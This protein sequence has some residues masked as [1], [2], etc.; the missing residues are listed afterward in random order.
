MP[1]LI[2]GGGRVASH[3][4]ELL[5]GAGCAVS[6]IA[7][8]AEDAIRAGSRHGRLDW[9]A[10]EFAAGDCRGFGLVVAAG[11][12]EEVNRAVAEESQRLGIPV[13]VVDAPELCTF[14]F[15]ATWRDGPLTVSV[16]SGG[17]APFMAAALRD[18]ISA[19]LEGMGSWVET[20]ARFRATVRQAT[21]D[22][23]ERRQLYRLFLRRI[24]RRKPA[25]AEPLRT[26]EEWL[27]WLE[28]RDRSTR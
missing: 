5:L 27:A 22:P 1:C 8:A 23:G 10:R 25:G 21:S 9:R 19:S 2:V 12:N 13:N 4:A 20:A 18:R 24:G 11:G 15:G 17:E 28:D 3:K 7:P 14:I 6:V 16:S 26:L